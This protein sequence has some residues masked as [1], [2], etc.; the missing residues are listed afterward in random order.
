MLLRNIV[1][2]FQAAWDM[3][4]DFPLP[5]MIRQKITGKSGAGY[6]G[7]AKQIMF[8]ILGVIAAFLLW[9]S[10][11]LLSLLLPQVPAAILFAAVATVL[12][13][14][15]TSGRNIAC[16]LSFAEQT[17]DR[18]PPLQALTELTADF[19]DIR[20]PIGTLMLTLL[21][22]FK[23]FCFFL[24][25]Y[26]EYHFWLF[27]V[28][29]LAFTS[30]AELAATTSMHSGKPLLFVAS[31]DRFHVW[32]MAIFFVLFVLFIAPVPSLL[33]IGVAFLITRLIRN[34][35]EQHFGGV[36]ENIISLCGFIVELTTLLIGML[37]LTRM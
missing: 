30:Q 32:I 13:E 16:L 22:L 5:Q 12:T 8:P 6:S 21:I 10:A 37:L 17:F 26:F 18:V 23:L 27:A 31:S 2:N 25:F 9:L 7:I 20:S 36:N 19:R 34:V 3:L 1:A 24:M 14:V 28:Y 15:A 4:I 11:A 29:I 33:A 35:C